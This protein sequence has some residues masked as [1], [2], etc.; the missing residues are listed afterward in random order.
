MKK[1]VMPLG[2]TNREYQ[3]EHLYSPPKTK[4]DKLVQKDN[5]IAS[6]VN[7]HKENEIGLGELLTEYMLITNEKMLPR[8]L[9][10]YSD[11]LN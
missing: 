1:Y 8:N 10:H 7:K 3:I 2:F 6:L 11:D 9:R 5:R 4:D